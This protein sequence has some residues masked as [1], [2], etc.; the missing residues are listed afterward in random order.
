MIESNFTNEILEICINRPDKKNALSHD[1][2]HELERLFREYGEHESCKA[3]ILHGAGNSFTAGAD[4]ND[5]KIKRGPGDSP[6]V[7]F[8]RSLCDCRAPVIAA[9]EGI[10]IGIGTTLLQHCDFVYTTA[11]TRF[12]MPFVAL[13]LGPEG[14]SSYLLEQIVG[15]RKARDWLMSGRFFDGREALDAGFVTELVGDGTALEKARETAKSLSALP[16]NSVR[17]TKAMLGEWYQSQTHSALDN[18]VKMF[19]EQLASSDTQSTITSTG[20]S[21]R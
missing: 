15:R 1:M 17:K 14:A 11:T 2:Y 16:F 8:L 5:F 4:L 12:R 6:G 21:G 19:A 9:A 3:I 10:A 13:G 18:E 20:K 7:K